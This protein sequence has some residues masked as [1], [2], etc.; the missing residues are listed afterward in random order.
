MKQNLHEQ[1]LFNTTP[2][3]IK[4]GWL[5]GVAQKKSP[6]FTPRSVH[7]NIELLVIHNISLPAGHFGGCYIDDLFL[8]QLDCKADSSFSD[9]KGV[10]VSAHCLIKR[11]GSITQYVS[12]DNKA[13]HA[14][15]STFNG[16]EKCN[17][18]SIGIELEGCDDT[19]YE[20]IQYKQLG[21][22]S[23][24]IQQAYPLIINDN[25]KGH[26]EIAPGRKTDPGKAFNWQHFQH[27][28]ALSE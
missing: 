6:F 22:L 28:L 23:A 11:D 8:G 20:E 7:D 5:T 15:I 25:I 10:E 26:C 17:D 4:N 1:A 14:G 3:E 13:W 27:Y 16:K 21:K 12:F 2:F 24:A 18:F 19:A 9:L